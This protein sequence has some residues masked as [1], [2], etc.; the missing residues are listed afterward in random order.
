MLSFLDG[1]QLTSFF[2]KDTHKDLQSAICYS[3]L[4][5]S[6]GRCHLQG[7]DGDHNFNEANFMMPE[8]Y[9]VIRDIRHHLD[10]RC[11]MVIIILMRLTS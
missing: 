5:L 9:S 8:S 3:M 6:L 10:I 7:R 4:L 1:Y 11:G 2:K